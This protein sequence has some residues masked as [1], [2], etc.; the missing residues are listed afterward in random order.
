M[1]SILIRIFTIMTLASSMAAFAG[2]KKT[3]CPENADATAQANQ[4][5]S[6]KKSKKTHDQQKPKKSQDEDPAEKEFDR[7]LLGT[8]G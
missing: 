5:E 1:K 8:H 6:M 3:S 4:H 2:T 7:L